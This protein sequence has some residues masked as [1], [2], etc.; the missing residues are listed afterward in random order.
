LVSIIGLVR[1]PLHR[2]IVRLA[3]HSERILRRRSTARCALA[4]LRLITVATLLPK[5]SAVRPRA[6]FPIPTE[7]A[8][9]NQSQHYART[10]AW[11]PAAED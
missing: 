5:R 4:V 2:E 11:P 3:G 7:S 6:N 10:V 1:R 9:A 8:R